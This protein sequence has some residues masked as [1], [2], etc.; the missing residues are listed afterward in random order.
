MRQKRKIGYKLCT[1]ALCGAL[2]WGGAME[3]WAAYGMSKGPGSIMQDYIVT[4]EAGIHPVYASIDSRDT[5]KEASQGEVYEVL[6]DEGDGWVE[7]QVGD[8]TGYI[9]TQEDG[10]KV[11]GVKEDTEEGAAAKASLEAQ[12]QEDISKSRRQNLVD[13]A[14]QFVGGRYVAGGS[15]PHTGAD[16]SGFSSYVM[17]HGAN[18]S[19]ARSSAAQAQQGVDV[20]ADQMR[21]GDLI[22]YGNGSRVNHVAL[23]IGNGQVVHA[24]TERTGIKTSP[25]NYRTPVRIKNVLGD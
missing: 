11:K 10:V 14:L 2:S 22:F 3:A 13:Y 15:D 5:L 24:S 4:I 23:Y 1:V 18:V 25:W 12:Q 20:S 17:L 19:I 8:D 6:S 9:L 7:V 21:P 16:C